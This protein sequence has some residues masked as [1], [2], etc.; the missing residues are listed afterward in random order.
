MR[1]GK[2]IL[3]LFQLIAIPLLVVGTITCKIWHMAPRVSL[4]GMIIFALAGFEIASANDLP[5]FAERVSR[6]KE[7]EQEEST[8]KYFKERMSPVAGPV[9]A[10]AIRMCTNHPCAN[11]DPFVMVADITQEGT[12]TQVDFEPKTD[13]SECFAN[14]VVR[15]RFPE[16]PTGANG[17]LPVVIE[18]KIAP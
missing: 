16:P 14:A 10:E 11:T 3:N 18:M 4:Y 9:I 12:L 5:T 15:F 1:K 17:T 2:L 13:S 7:I 8:Q 6:A